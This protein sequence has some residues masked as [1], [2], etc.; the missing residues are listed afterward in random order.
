MSGKRIMLVSLVVLTLASLIAACGKPPAGGPTAPP[1]GGT[2]IFGRGGDTIGLDPAV[3]T[4]GESFRVSGQILEP[5]YEYDKGTTKTIPALASECTANTNATEWTCKLRQ[6]VKFHDGTPFNA[7]AVIFNYERW[8]FTTNP[9]HYP[10]Q[11]FEYYE[12]MWGGFDDASMIAKLEKIDDYTVKFILSAPLAPFLANLAMEPFVISSPAAIK[13]CG[14]KYGTP[15][16]GAVGTG[17]FIF[18][19]WV[20][21]DHITVVANDNFWDGRPYIDS[22]VWKVIKDDSARFLALKSGEIHATEQAT[23]ED[24][25]VAESDPNLYILTRPALNTG[26]LAFNYKIK[27]FQDKR[28]REAVAHAIN[29][30]A[31]VQ[32]FYGK[33]GEVATNMIPP[34]VWGH[35]ADVKDWEYNP[36]LSKSLLADAGFPN[37]LSE[38]TIAEDIKD[39]DG[40]VV[41]KAGDKIPL[42]FYYMPVT[43][44]YYPNPKAIGEAMAADLNKAGIK[45]TMELAGDWATYLGLRRT[46][47][48]VGLYML[49]WGGDNGDP[50]NFNGYFFGGLSSETE[51]KAPDPREGWYANQQVASLCYK[52]LVNPNQAEREVMYK[53]TEQLLHDDVAR[54]WVV[55]NNTP[56]IFNKKVQGYVPEPVGDD[57]YRW[58]YILP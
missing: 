55:H 9:Y 13:K 5:L 39:K 8:R 14:E 44:F 32:N 23:S 57:Y 18:K 30:Q 4:D 26:Y 34:L 47:M 6:N 45:V 46:G 48:L 22:I 29:R 12:A 43:R 7:D 28:V 17:P 2:F 10:S 49:G 54:I 50:D 21:D 40:N 38:V 1:K 33:Y 16:C 56:L 41:Y 19:E 35:N 27:E 20:P 42:K 31:L 11:V 52:A 15:E 37:G 24:L 53:Q 58:V 3:V 25:A 36:D 51:A